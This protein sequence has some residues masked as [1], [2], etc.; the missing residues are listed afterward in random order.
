MVSC[1]ISSRRHAPRSR[2]FTL[3]ELLV[4]ISIIGVLIA[5]LLPAV[6][7]ARASARRIQCANNLHQIGIAMNLYIDSQGMNGK[8]PYAAEMPS[9]EKDTDPPSLRTVLAPYIESNV[10]VCC[11][12]SDTYFGEGASQAG[13][14]FK[15]VGISYAYNLM[16]LVDEYLKGKTRAQALK[17]RDG[18]DIPSATL[19]VVYD[20]YAF[21]G[22][23]GTPT[24]IVIL[25]AD[26]HA[27]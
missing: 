4:V 23:K 25:Y 15:N 22:T 21:H 6:Q 5:L 9:S 24:S 11:C 1:Q 18:T 12:P 14:T 19:E 2:G 26:G 16:A 7:A 27:E 8:Y 3:V 10:S 17:D 13:S 20:S